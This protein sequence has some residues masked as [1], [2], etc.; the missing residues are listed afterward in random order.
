M[1]KYDPTNKK[2]LSSVMYGVKASS[3]RYPADIADYAEGVLK[4]DFL[5]EYASHV[6][7]VAAGDVKNIDLDGLFGGKLSGVE[8]VALRNV[9]S[10][11][12]LSEANEAL[13]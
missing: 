10:K 1:G 12:L 3:V 11:W 6:L 2:E 4:S 13:Q 9:I 5:P 7:E 8:V